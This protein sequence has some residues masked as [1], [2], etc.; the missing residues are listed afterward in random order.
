VYI[1]LEGEGERHI[2]IFHVPHVHAAG[3]IHNQSEIRGLIALTLST[4]NC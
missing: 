2:H 1:I 3:T 4:A